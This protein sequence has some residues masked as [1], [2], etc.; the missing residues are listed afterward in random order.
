MKPSGPS[1]G[2]RHR[3]LAVEPPCRAS[4]VRHQDARSG[5]GGTKGSARPHARRR[6]RREEER[7]GGITIA[8]QFGGACRWIERPRV[9]FG[10]GQRAAFSRR[11]VGN[12]DCDLIR[13]I[14][15]TSAR[16]GSFAQGPGA[17]GACGAGRCIESGAGCRPSCGV[18]SGAGCRAGRGVQRRRSRPVFRR[19][20][21]RRIEEAQHQWVRRSRR[22]PACCPQRGPAGRRERDWREAP[23]RGAH[24]ATLARAAER[25]GAADA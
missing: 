12:H 5:A 8:G 11:L 4:R 1:A 22:S 20:R 15:T 23:C 24:A 10:V 9:A 16:S 19:R 21:R 14:G 25:Q 13:D 2:T 17:A 7:I 18:E 3:R 6:A